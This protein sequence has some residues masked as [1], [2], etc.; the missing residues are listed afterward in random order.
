MKPFKEANG[1]P[2]EQCNAPY[3]PA[4]KFVMRVGIPHRSGKLAFHAFENEYP[5]M[6][7]AN[8]F[9]DPNKQ[10]FAL[11]KATDLS[12]CDTAVDSGGFSAMSLWKSNGPQRGMAG[13][14]PWTVSEYIEFAT[15]M[16]AS[17]WAA[18]DLCCE[19][20]LAGN[21]EEVDFRVRATA[22][23]LEATLQQLYIWHCELAKT[24]NARTIANMLPPPV[25][26][27]QGWDTA[28]YQ[29]SA[30]LLQ[31]VWERWQP[32]LAAPALIGVG[33]VCRRPVHHPKHGLLN[34]LAGIEG[35]LPRG[36]RVH[37]FGVKGAAPSRVKL[38]PWVG[39]ADS[40]AYDVGA[41][42]KAFR[43]GFSNC[44]EHRTREMSAWMATAAHRMAPAAG[45]QTRLPFFT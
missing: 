33:S 35:L 42:Q 39:S 44:V 22:T 37:L 2:I 29:Q 34:V 32:W 1:L 27:L 14:F 5:V 3:E 13:I 19:P 8:A 15:S 4:G 25:P 36:S 24:C 20:E 18:P 12:E 26:V 45:D 10:A 6:V 41:R 23:L 40:M 17:W 7:S 11:P 21:E 31:R 28:S 38:L 9:W 16:G 43:G 30:E